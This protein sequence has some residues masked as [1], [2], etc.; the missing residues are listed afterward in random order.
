MKGFVLLFLSCLLS[1]ALAEITIITKSDIAG[2][3]NLNSNTIGTNENSVEKSD[4]IVAAIF[5]DQLPKE[6]KYDVN[7]KCSW[8]HCILKCIPKI[9]VCLK[10]HCICVK[11]P[12]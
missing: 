7:K 10:G 8:R 3:E 6:Q 1:A 9:G 4:D 5:T 2:Y 11:K 12:W